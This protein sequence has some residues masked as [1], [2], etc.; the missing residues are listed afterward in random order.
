MK[1]T[2]PTLNDFIAN[3]Y[4]RSGKPDGYTEKGAY[5]VAFNERIA[6]R[7]GGKHPLRSLQSLQI[8]HYRSGEIESLIELLEFRED[9]DRSSRTIVRIDLSEAVSVEEILVGLLSLPSTQERNPLRP[10][11]DEEF[12]K[13]LIKALKGLGL[14]LAPAAS[15]DDDDADSAITALG[16][17]PV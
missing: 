7:G 14:A 1:N 2:K 5:W 4:C 6:Q 11:V 15:P 12:E 3:Q 10:V 9:V 17:L 16:E 8:R 13:A